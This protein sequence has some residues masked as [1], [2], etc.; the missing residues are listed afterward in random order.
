MDFLSSPDVA[1]KY[2]IPLRTV[3]A[4]CQLGMIK[5]RRFGRMWLIPPEEAEAYAAQ[6]RPHIHRNGHRAETL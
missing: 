5:A 1:T 3:Q 6:W 2:G 4:A